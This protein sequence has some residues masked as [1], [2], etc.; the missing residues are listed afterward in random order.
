M[1]HTNLFIVKCLIGPAKIEN[2]PI[3]QRAG[4]GV[5]LRHKFKILLFIFVWQF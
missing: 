5:S 2:I 4:F 3:L 1:I